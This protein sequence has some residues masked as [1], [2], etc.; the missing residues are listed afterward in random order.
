MPI[1]DQLTLVAFLP[2]FSDMVQ[3]PAPLVV[4]LL[5]V[6]VDQLPVT[7]APLTCES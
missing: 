3:V 2:R 5:A 6:P 7:V 4:Q 1:T